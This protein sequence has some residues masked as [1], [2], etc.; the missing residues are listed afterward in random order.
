MVNAGI[1]GA[2]ERAGAELLANPLAWDASLSGQG[3]AQLSGAVPVLYIGTT[4]TPNHGSGTSSQVAEWDK[5][6]KDVTVGATQGFEVRPY[7]AGSLPHS[8]GNTNRIMPG[9]GFYGGT[10]HYMN[11]DAVIDPDD[12]LKYGIGRG[13]INTHYVYTA[14]SVSDL[15]TWLSSHSTSMLTFFVYAFMR[16]VG[17][18]NTNLEYY[19][20]TGV[21]S[22]STSLT[23]GSVLYNSTPPNPWFQDATISA[24][25][26]SGYTPNSN[27]NGITSA[28]AFL[29]TFGG[30]R[31]GIVLPS[32]GDFMTG[33]VKGYRNWT[34][35]NPDQLI[36]TDKVYWRHDWL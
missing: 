5:D 2:V 15:S 6:A 13:P 31:G 29:M 23:G 34:A 9:D 22:S 7:Q 27:R 3:L 32:A 19:W 11:G 28:D 33:Y 25:S 1:A 20:E 14:M 16:N 30:G 26:N 24:A 18:T 10:G 35:P 12:N 21:E 4:A 36:S 8:A 17:S